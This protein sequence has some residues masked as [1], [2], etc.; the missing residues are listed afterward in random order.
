MLSASTISATCI[1][2]VIL[3]PKNVDIHYI[4]VNASGSIEKENND[5]WR[6]Q[7]WS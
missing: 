4:D 3:F 5:N 7:H 2:F 6:S 1:L